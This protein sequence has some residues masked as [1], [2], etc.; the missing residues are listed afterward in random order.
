MKGAD[1]E[2]LCARPRHREVWR[3]TKPNPVTRGPRIEPSQRLDE[4]VTAGAVH[5]TNKSGKDER[6]TESQCHQ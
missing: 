3:P 2:S 4:G 1:F 5:A 6:Q